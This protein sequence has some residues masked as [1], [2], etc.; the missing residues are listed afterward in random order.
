MHREGFSLNF[1]TLGGESCSR[2]VVIAF[3]EEVLDR[4]IEAKLQMCVKYCGVR[5]VVIRG[6]RLASFFKKYFFL[7]GVRSSSCF[8]FVFISIYPDYLLVTYYYYLV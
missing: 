8:H 2:H 5:S 1:G 6:V 4:S 3:V 7:P